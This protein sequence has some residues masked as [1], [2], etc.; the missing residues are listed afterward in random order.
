M[1]LATTQPGGSELPLQRLVVA[2]DTGGAIRG[3]I[4]ADLFFGF[5]SEAGAQAG[6]MKYPGEMWVLWPRGAAPPR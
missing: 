3:P 5:G 1:F 4:R 2:Q 6:M